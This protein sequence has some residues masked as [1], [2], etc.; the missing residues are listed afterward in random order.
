MIRHRLRWTVAGLL[1]LL[2]LGL[3]GNLLF[4][5]APDA[6]ARWF[7]GY[8]DEVAMVIKGVHDAAAVL[9]VLAL[10]LWLIGMGREL[11][12]L[13]QSSAR[14][15]DGV[16]ALEI[17]IG[18]WDSD[19]RLIA[20]NDAFR[21]LYPEIGDRFIPGVAYLELVRAYYPLAPADVI[22]GRSFERFVGDAERQ[23]ANPQVGEI[24]RHHRGRWLLVTDVRNDSGGITSLRMDVTEQRAFDLELRKRRKVLDDLAELTSDWYWRTD[25]EGRFTEFSEAMQ[26]ALQYRP[27][28]LLGKRIDEIPGFAADA[29][30]LTTFRALV[31]KR[32]P[33]PWLNCRVKR[34]DGVQIWLAY[35]G[36]P[37]FDTNRTFLG[38]YGAGRDVS[39]RESTI[40]LLRQSEERFRALTKLATEWYWETD[41]QL[42]ITQLHGPPE[43]EAGRQAVLLGKTLESF[44][45]DAEYTID[46]EA[47]ESYLVRRAPFRRLP[48]R[49][50]RDGWQGPAYYESSAEPMF[51]DGQF[52]GYRGLAWDVTER[53]TTDRA[54][55]PERRAFS[56]TDRAVVRL[57]LGD[58]RAA[59][60]HPLA[61]GR[62]A[63]RSVSRTSELVGKHRWELPGELIRPSSWDDHRAALAGAPAV[64]RRDRSALDQ[65]G[66]PLSTRSPAVI[67][68]STPTAISCGYR[69][70]G[71]NITEQV[72]SQE[73][74]ER[75]ATMDEL[76]QLANRPT[77]DERAGRILGQRIRRGKALRVAVHRSR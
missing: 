40:E 74:I 71:N 16:E 23:R 15:Q 36:R 7:G 2:L 76:T 20:C 13:R 46:R 69:G 14:L 53:E 5:F 73:R 50:Q 65:Q 10:V 77:F 49:I 11:S 59:A 3:A 37:I 28:E 27:D 33:V 55:A 43:L 32:E 24:L 22:D 70:I 62:H 57:V 72:R 8:H 4:S 38:Y 56:R 67:R 19:D 25:G 17:G 21:A 42:R 26:R 58:G 61:P 41:A 51:V 34:A 12:R 9:V 31:A 75:L 60:F 48:Y 35:T 68:S 39:D 1:V 47:V 6:A 63:S 66:D 64:S 30:T 52:S 45:D 44:G 29:Q 18:L 54:A